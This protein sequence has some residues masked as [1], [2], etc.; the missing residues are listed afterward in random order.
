MNVFFNIGPILAGVGV[1]GLA[2][3][4][5]AQSMV[6]DM[7]AGFFILLEDQFR[8]G[9]V[10]AI[11][12]VSGIVERITLRIVVLRDLE[13]VVHVIPNGDVGVVSNKTRSWARV[14]LDVGVA[15]G[16]KRQQRD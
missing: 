10:V 3:S 14:V 11:A 5:G 9:D 6:K 4:F 1:L 13:G 2:V 8:V 12:G 16:G 15:Y 7:I